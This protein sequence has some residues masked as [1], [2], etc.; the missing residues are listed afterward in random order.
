MEGLTTNPY[1]VQNILLLL[2]EV[3]LDL[4]TVSSFYIDLVNTHDILTKMKWKIYKQ[5]KKNN[6]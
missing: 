1:T 3:F 2:T 6:F 4:F 5:N